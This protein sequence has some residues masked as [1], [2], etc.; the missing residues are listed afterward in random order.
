MGEFAMKTARFLLFLS[1]FA[2]IWSGC[3]SD[4]DGTE[5]TPTEIDV[6]GPI[7]TG[8]T[9]SGTVRLTADADINAGVHVIIAKGSVFQGADGA[10]LRVHGNLSINGTVA[11]PISMNPAVGATSWGGIVVESGGVA[12]LHNVTG[13]KVA[14]LLT[15]KTGALACVIDRAVFSGLGQAL[16]ASSE[17]AIEKSVFEDVSTNAVVVNTGGNVTIT[18][19]VIRGGP[20]DL[21]IMNG[22]A[23][24]M[25]YCDIGSDLTSEF[26]DLHISSS[27]GLNISYS[28]IISSE[29]GMMIGGTSNA[30]LNYN[31]F[32]NNN[33]DVYSLGSNTA[34]DMSYNYW[35]SGI[36]SGLGSE[37][38]FNNTAA[39]PIS[40]A[41]PRP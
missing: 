38:T 40:N 14:T 20:A 36:P 3:G 29:Y 27:T 6:S 18:D 35:D 25:S 13:S 12:Q 26:G 4:D 39:A 34:I 23:L 8:A 41:G 37:F 11:N 16:D 28:N 31:N 5:P 33:Y 24:T 22:G 2:M 1:F 19:T 9:W 10:V 7:S 30:Q 17:V 15:C 21:V 32:I